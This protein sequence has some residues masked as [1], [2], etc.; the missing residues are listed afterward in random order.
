MTLYYLKTLNIVHRDIKPDNIM[1]MYSVSN[2]SDVKTI[3]SIKLMDFG[4]SQF[5]GTNEFSTHPFG[6]LTYVAPE[7]ISLIPYRFE[8]DVYSVGVILYQ[9][10]SGHVPFDSAD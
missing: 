10:C 3:P 7:V 4:L 2:T 1:L 9:M 6:T 8:V 5:M